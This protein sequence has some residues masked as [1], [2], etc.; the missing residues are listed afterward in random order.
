MG[1]SYFW[2]EPGEGGEARENADA[3][4]LGYA[5]IHLL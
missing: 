5:L 4:L 1:K 2:S 3:S